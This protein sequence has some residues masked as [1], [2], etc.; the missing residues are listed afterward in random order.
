MG[1]GETA[2]YLLGST[3]GAQGSSSGGVGPELGWG[4]RIPRE[5]TLR[6]ESWPSEPWQRQVGRRQGWRNVGVHR[7]Q[8]GRI[9]GICASS[10]PMAWCCAPAITVLQETFE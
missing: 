2:G 9:F 4:L 3:L 8:K 1:P 6:S 10:F 7:T 5:E